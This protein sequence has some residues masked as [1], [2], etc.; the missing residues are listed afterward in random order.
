[1]GILQYK[2]LTRLILLVLL[3]SS[4]S[5]QF[6]WP[7]FFPVRAPPS[8]SPA[9]YTPGVL[10]LNSTGTDNGKA[11]RR[12]VAPPAIAT[13][14]ASLAA[15][16][17]H[18][19]ASWVHSVSSTSPSRDHCNLTTCMVKDSIAFCYASMPPSTTPLASDL[20]GS[21]PPTPV[22]HSSP[23]LDNATSNMHLPTHCLTLCHLTHS[24]CHRPTSHSSQPTTLLLQ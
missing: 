19:T 7:S 12:M 9:V 1:M 10:T 21:T 13:A 2:G 20:T 4:V 5:A 17:P 11:D 8:P 18:N 6:L 24:I 14:P 16:S 3:A 15:A 22:D 23:L